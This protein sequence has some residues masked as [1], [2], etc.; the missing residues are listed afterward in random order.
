MAEIAELDSNAGRT[1]DALSAIREA[2]PLALQCQNKYAVHKFVE[3]LKSL[4]IDPLTL[5]GDHS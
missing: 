1:D 4:G 2:L 3:I 5:L